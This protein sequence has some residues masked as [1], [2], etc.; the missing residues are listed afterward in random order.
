MSQ[1]EKI[2]HLLGIVSNR[3]KN[4][5][6]K[7]EDIRNKGPSLNALTNTVENTYHKSEAFKK[8]PKKSEPKSMFSLPTFLTR[9]ENEKKSESGNSYDTENINLS[10]LGNFSNNGDTLNLNVNAQKLLAKY[11][12]EKKENTNNYNKIL[13]SIIKRNNKNIHLNKSLNHKNLQ[14]DLKRL[15]NIIKTERYI[16][17]DMQGKIDKLNKKSENVDKN[18]IPLKIKF[19]KSKE[20]K[21]KKS[22]YEQEKKLIENTKKIIEKTKKNIEENIESKLKEINVNLN[23]NK[24]QSF[25]EMIAKIGTENE[26]K[27]RIQQLK[28]N[29]QNILKHVTPIRLLKIGG[30]NDF[31]EI[32]H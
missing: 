19:F 15:Q 23:L 30:S 22:N 11:I 24:K 26:R 28:K 10:D 3:K 25:K 8:K 32:D 27:K 4:A 9:S 20:N 21:K 16:L 6:K 5:E 31:T 29:R 7:I 12:S 13:N 14:D 2:K 1:S 18:L 17:D